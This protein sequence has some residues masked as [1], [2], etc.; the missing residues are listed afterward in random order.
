ML[1]KLL[2]TKD[3]EVTRKKQAISKI[4]FL[5]AI[6]LSVLLAHILITMR[7]AEPAQKEPTQVLGEEIK[8]NTE[9][10]TQIQEGAADLRNTAE[11]LRQELEVSTEHIVV[12]GKKK[13]EDT[14]NQ[15]L[16]DTTFRPVVEK[17]NTLPPQQQEYLKKQI[18]E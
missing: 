7:K 3:D 14:A 8:Q 9:L 10:K 4:L 5:A 11:H 16:Y 13:V 17:F 1:K 6:G 2:P 18:C 12:E 15:I